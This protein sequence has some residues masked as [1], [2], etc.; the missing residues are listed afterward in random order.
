MEEPNILVSNQ[1][2]SWPCSPSMHSTCASQTQAPFSAQSLYMWIL[3][4]NF[5]SSVHSKYITKYHPSSPWQSRALQAILFKSTIRWVF[6]HAVTRIS[7]LSQIAIHMICI[8][9]TFAIEWFISA[10]LRMWWS[11]DGLEDGLTRT[12][13]SFHTI[14]AWFS[15]KIEPIHDKESLCDDQ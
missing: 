4:S 10:S 8:L 14:T 1:T 5:F 15:R 7:G 12:L 11:H 9:C 3:Q 6:I 2:Q 13:W